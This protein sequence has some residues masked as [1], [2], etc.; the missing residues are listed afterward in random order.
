MHIVL[1]FFLFGA[2]STP[3]H[4]FV[5][6]LFASCVYLYS[7]DPTALLCLLAIGVILTCTLP[8]SCAGWGGGGRGSYI[9]LTCFVTWRVGTAGGGPVV[10]GEP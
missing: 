10:G 7:R 1:M 6:S 8:L 3:P 2:L 9:K 5:Y 4:R